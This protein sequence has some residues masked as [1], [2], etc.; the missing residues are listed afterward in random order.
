MISTDGFEAFV[1]A[2]NLRRLATDEVS[3]ERVR[4]AFLEAAMP[5]WL[6]ADLEVFLSQ[7]IN[8]LS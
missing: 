7:V 6:V 2:N 1:E 4:Q 5:D 8:P 3:D